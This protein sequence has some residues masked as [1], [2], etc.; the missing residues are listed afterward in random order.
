MQKEICLC[1]FEFM[2]FSVMVMLFLLFAFKSILLCSVLASVFI[3]LFYL[4]FRLHLQ[5]I[6]Y[7][8][9]VFLL[10]YIAKSVFTM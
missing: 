6:L 9:Y 10:N 8:F 7:E 2:G 1:M 4:F 5:H 3:H